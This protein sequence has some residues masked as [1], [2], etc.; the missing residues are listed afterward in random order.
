MIWYNRE[1]EIEREKGPGQRRE[2]K[3]EE[4]QQER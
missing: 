4:K 1:D 3:R 2:R